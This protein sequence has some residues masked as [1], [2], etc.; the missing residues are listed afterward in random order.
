[1]TVGVEAVASSPRELASAMASEMD[2]LGRLVKE[3][4]LRSP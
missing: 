3:A 1:M 2:R 4:R